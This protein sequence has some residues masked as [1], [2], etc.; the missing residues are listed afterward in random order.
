MPRRRRGSRPSG[1]GC[2]RWRGTCPGHA[3]HQQL[4][5]CPD[6][7]Q[8]TRHGPWFPPASASADHLGLARPGCG[9]RVHRSSVHLPLGRRRGTVPRPQRSPL[10]GR[11]L[12]SLFSACQC[13]R[14]TPSPGKP[15][16]R[17]G[18]CG[19][20]RPGAA[21]PPA[22]CDVDAGRPRSGIEAGRFACRAWSWVR[23][24]RLERVQWDRLDRQTGRPVEELG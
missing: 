5:R 3:T 22:P 12:G 20:G 17:P 14:V 9:P 2:R 16:P 8:A 23:S 18:R 4:P 11:S 6:P 7:A 1:E 13:R 10:G 19:R 15:A 24:R 21:R